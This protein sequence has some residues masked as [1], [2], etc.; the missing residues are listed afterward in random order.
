MEN[1]SSVLVIYTGGTIGMFKDA[2]TGALRPVNFDDLGDYIPALDL[3]DFRIDS[4]SFDPI[5]DSSNMSQELW[6]KLAEVIEKNYEEYDGLSFFMEA[7]P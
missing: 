3:F 4:Y 6:V 7:I 5:I 1:Q 2:E